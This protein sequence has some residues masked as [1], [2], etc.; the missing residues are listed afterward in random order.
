MIQKQSR[1]SRSFF[2]FCDYFNCS[3]HFAAAGMDA[4]RFIETKFRRLQHSNSVDSGTSSMGK[5]FKDMDTDS[6]W[7]FYMEF[8][9]VDSDYNVYPGAD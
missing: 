3:Y 7:P 8:T 9:Q 6:S 2:L 4:E 1:I 5:L